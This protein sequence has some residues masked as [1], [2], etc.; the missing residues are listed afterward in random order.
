MKLTSTST[1]RSFYELKKKGI[2]ATYTFK[3]IE[4]LVLD[5]IQMHGHW[6]CSQ[7]MV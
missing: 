6:N 5:R 1:A 2:K 3:Q 7:K 4:I